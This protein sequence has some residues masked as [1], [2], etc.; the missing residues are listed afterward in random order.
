MTSTGGQVRTIQFRDI[1]HMDHAGDPQLGNVHG[2]RFYLTGPHRAD[3]APLC[4]KRKAADPVEQA[5]HG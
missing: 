5:A 3:T 1:P 2:K 4:R